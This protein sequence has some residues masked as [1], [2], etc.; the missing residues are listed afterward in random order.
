MRDVKNFLTN[1]QMP[2]FIIYPHCTR[3]SRLYRR[4]IA[5]PRVSRERKEKKCGKSIFVSE[6]KS[7]GQKSLVD[8]RMMIRTEAK[9]AMDDDNKLNDMKLE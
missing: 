6:G 5:A 9:A 3:H 2:A 1:C 7:N 4:I 8:E